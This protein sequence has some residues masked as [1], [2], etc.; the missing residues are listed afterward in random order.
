MAMLR[1][2]TIY[3]QTDGGPRPVGT[4]HLPVSGPATIAFL[5]G[6][7]RGEAELVFGQGFGLRALGRR[8]L[9][10]ERDL[11]VDAVRETFARSSYWSVVEDE[12]G[13]G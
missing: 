4:I 12:T 7:Y 2:F 6:E 13:G 9:P 10:D 1:T 11:F 8:I 5:D 3:R